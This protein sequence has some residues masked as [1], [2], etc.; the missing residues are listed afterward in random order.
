[1][2]PVSNYISQLILNVITSCI[3]IYNELKIKTDTGCSFIEY[4]IYFKES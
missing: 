1:M 3:Y 4:D 2:L